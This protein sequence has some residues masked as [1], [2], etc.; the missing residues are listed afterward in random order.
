MSVKKVIQG[1]LGGGT[2]SS[3]V[4]ATAYNIE[5]PYF[6]NV[7]LLVTSE[8][9]DPNWSSV[10]LLMSGEDLLDHSTNAYA[11]TMTNTVS[12]N[13]AYN[14]YGAGSLYFDGTSKL[15][16]YS[17]YLIGATDNTFTVEM[18]VY[19][20]A[21][22]SGTYSTVP[23][24]IA[25]NSTGGTHYT[26][27]GVLPNR[28][29]GMYY[30]PGT[31]SY[32]TTVLNLNQWYHIAVSVSNNT[33]K[34]FINGVQ[35]ATDFPTL[36]NR[37]GDAT[38]F[39]IG[40]NSYTTFTGYIDDLR[41]TNG[42]ARYTANFTPPTT[43]LPGYITD[44]SNLNNSFT[45][46]GNTAIN[47]TTK[48]YGNSS[49]YFDGT[50]SYVTVPH[51]QDLEFGSAD[52][53][54]E[55]W[56]N[57]TAVRTQGI[58]VKGYHNIQIGIYNT[59]LQVN[60]SYER[61]IGY[62]NS[63]F[64][65]NVWYHVAVVRQGNM[66]H[67]YING[68]L[69]N[70]LT[71]TG[72]D[73]FTGTDP[74]C[75]G[76]DN[77]VGISGYFSGY[78]DDLRVTSGIARYTGP[79]TPPI[80][81][82]ST[83][84]PTTDPYFNNVTLLLNGDTEDVDPYWSSVSLLLSGDGANT[85]TTFTDSSTNNLS[86]TNSST[87]S[88]NA[89]I[90]KYGT[91][92]MYFDGAGNVLTVSNFPVLGTGDF[93]IET[94]VYKISGS[95][96]GF[97][98]LLSS[99]TWPSTSSPLALGHYTGGGS[100]LVDCGG[101]GQKYSSLTVSNNTWYHVALV[102]SSGVTKFYVNGVYDSSIGAI[103]DTTN[104]TYTYLGIGAY[105]TTSYSWN[106]YLDD[107][108]VT[109]GIARYTA[110]FTPPTARLPSLQ[111]YDKSNKLVPITPYGNARI[112]SST[113]K[114]NTGSIYFD[115]TDDRIIINSS[116]ILTGD[117]T[118]E[119]WVNRSTLSDNR[120][121]AGSG[122]TGWVGW[123][124]NTTFFVET[125]TE[126]GTFTIANTTDLWAHYAIVRSSGVIRVFVNGVMASQSIT[127]STGTLTIAQI[128]G[129]GNGYL[130]T[131]YIDDFRITKGVARYTATFTPPAR[132]LPT[133]L[134]QNIDPYYD[135]V[136]LLLSG[137]PYDDPFYSNVK[138]LM[139]G[140]DLLDKSP[141]PVTLTTNGSVAVT[142]NT[143]ISG[144][145]SIY[146]DGSSYLSLSLSTTAAF[147]F[148]CWFYR[149]AA[150]S[151]ASFNFFIGT[152]GTGIAFYNNGSTIRVGSQAFTVP[153][154][155][156][157]WV[158][159]AV[160]RDSS[161][162]IRVFFNGIES[163][164]GTLN[165]AGTFGWTR[166]G[167]YNTMYFFQ[168]YMDDIRLTNDVVR[169]TSNF[170]PPTSLSFN[171]ISDKSQYANTV[172]LTGDTKVDTN[173][174]KYGYGSIYFDGAGDK[175]Q[176]SRD[177]INLSFGDFTYESWIYPTNSS[178][179]GTLITTGADLSAY[180]DWFNIWQVGTSI[181]L[182]INGT[183][184]GWNIAGGTNVA[185]VTVNAWNHIAFVRYG[186]NFYLFINGEQKWTTTSSENLNGNTPFNNIYIGGS[187]SGS[188]P[189]TGYMDDIRIT[190]GV[191]RYI[192]NFTPPRRSLPTAGLPTIT[193][194]YVDDVF[195]VYAYAGTSAKNDI[196]TGI[197]LTN[198]GGLVW[199]KSRDNS[200]FGGNSLYD[201][202]RGK[203]YLLSCSG[204]GSQVATSAQVNTYDG[205]NNFLS[206]NSDGFSLGAD[207]WY[208]KNNSGNSY[209]AWTFKRA[210]K[211]FD[212]VTTTNGGNV[213]ITHSLGTAPGMI[214]AKRIDSSENWWVY[215]RGFAN[216]DL[217]NCDLLK[218][219]LTDA[220]VTGNGTFGNVTASNFFFRGNSGGAYVF[221]LFAHDPSA[222]G[223][224]QCG[225]FTASNDLVINLG[226][227]PQF[228]MVK[229]TN[230]T[231]DWEILDTTRGWKWGNN[232]DSAVAKV[233]CANLY[234]TE[235]AEKSAASSISPYSSGFRIPGY[236]GWSADFIYMAIRR[237]NKP[238]TTGTQVFSPVART[239]TGAATTVS[240]GFPVDTV[241][242][243]RRASGGLYWMNRITGN[244]LYM[245][246]SSAAVEATTYT[247]FDSSTGIKLDSSNFNDTPFVDYFFKRAPGFFD[248]V[249]W[250][251]TGSTP[252]IYHKLGV[253]PEMIIIKSRTNDTIVG[254][255]WLTWVAGLKNGN[256]V[257][258]STGGNWPMAISLNSNGDMGTYNGWMTV[259]N[260]TNIQPTYHYS[261]G[262]NYIAYFF[263]SC[264]GVSK[265]GSYTGNGGTQTINCGFASGARFVL[266]KRTNSTGDWYVWD[267]ARGIVGANDPH[268]SFNT[269]SAE[270]TTDDSVDPH[271]SGF[272]V[273]QLA[274]TNIN[275]LNASYIFLAIA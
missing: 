26:S 218:L 211:F 260:T 156:N 41:V 133:L 170:V 71:C 86:I 199:I 258:L 221:Y 130:F 79:F 192:T 217:A 43:S 74:V 65:T 172:I 212:V 39:E 191:A 47:T 104:Y 110:N 108:R 72:T 121:L 59:T 42:V 184:G 96:N 162:N 131:G 268:L 126:N 265:I 200:I 154:L 51:R 229:R 158:H 241:I 22:P 169:Y 244:S 272:T 142:A 67:I 226:W 182:Y 183:T 216:T 132:A 246:S 247:G 88:I 83:T 144:S 21:A 171:N 261:T 177:N 63:S 248:V 15:Y 155:I 134:D 145:G 194:N 262:V 178:G 92:S 61:V 75:I 264:A 125:L 153:D 231:G 113:V 34:Y 76:A 33:I 227:E 44:K 20:T 185:G 205:T 166:I 45:V 256:Y 197:N 9:E 198:E 174:K 208:Y 196:K 167:A 263:A 80:E 206:F 46:K 73:V 84:V 147:T 193:T 271:S 13:T 188:V 19:M 31:N 111:V 103:T 137:D 215:H 136:G 120:V 52:F 214:L 30:Y 6:N 69:D 223:I 175:L 274:A 238:P 209:V 270:V 25:L 89:S 236:G 190:K 4:A 102:R 8:V 140:N 115:G 119:A 27:F 7:S 100:W 146:F 60:D 85:S 237:P 235:S 40:T 95:N 98:Q 242:H 101:S 152:S 16:N 180:Y 234:G 273:N 148:E 249:C 127:N 266:I 255:N 164:T 93:T 38:G 1:M 64:V 250:T 228:I 53:T 70:S 5:D 106:G 116:T 123:N 165:E 11:L 224:I 12:V 135:K 141:S 186:I 259:N 275:V 109:K 251:G 54:V 207:S 201:T 118:I 210:R 17:N 29:L 82:L 66:I 62:S 90:K 23:S 36:T 225:S 157:Q 128:N 176:V 159:L 222:D 245:N 230:G 97:L 77:S 239:N 48:K 204:D 150:V 35:D 99:T 18:W 87:V 94:W 161:N 267:S 163:I 58:Y 91:G 219:N 107:I 32:A 220:V 253:T 257:N 105:W 252:T 10:K 56:M 124:N 138:L 187:A 173:V 149:T 195:N 122:S 112:N 139:N 179:A 49:V 14:R 254:N 189:Y 68:N 117:F 160:T 143:R 50:N 2:S 151:S 129:Q 240:S 168:G 243:G 81:G 114:Y 202:V 181:R 28:K 37:S 57:C 213:T 78:I 232:Y 24:G 203:Q 233:L 55:W 3:S 269:S